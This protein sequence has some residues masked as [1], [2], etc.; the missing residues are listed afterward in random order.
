MEND[1][2]TKKSKQ[3][4]SSSGASRNTARVDHQYE[5]YGVE[6]AL[7]ESQQRSYNPGE[8]P[9]TNDPFPIFLHYMLND[10]E[11]NGLSHIVS[12]CPHGRAFVVHNR[13]LFVKSVLPK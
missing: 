2:A 7:L 12:W 8:P 3:S 6:A 1:P 13:E 10:T 11:K 5:D 9:S 4:D